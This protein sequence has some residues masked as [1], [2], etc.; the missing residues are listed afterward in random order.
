MKV[1]FL[2]VIDAAD[3]Q[4][5]LMKMASA[6]ELVPNGQRFEVT[7]EDLGK[8]PSS[9]FA[10][11]ASE[12]LRRVFADVKP[13]ETEGRTARV[14]LQSADDFRF[15]R[16]WWEPTCTGARE[17]W[18]CFTKG[19]TFC[20]FYSDVGLVVEW[21]GG[22]RQMKAF[23]ETTPGTRHWSRNLRSIEY[24]FRP[25]ITWTVRTTRNLS[26]RL[27]PSGCIFAHKGPV[28]FVD[29]DNRDDL[30]ALLA[31][32]VSSTFR[33]LVELQLA[34]VDAAARSYEVGVI[35]RTPIPQLDLPGK[36]ALSLLSLKAWSLR[37]TIDMSV[38]SSHAFT[39]PALLQVDGRDFSERKVA[40][41]ERVHA[42]ETEQSRIQN[43]IDTLC[44]EFYGLDK[45]DSGHLQEDRG[46]PTSDESEFEGLGESDFEADLPEPEDMAADI[47]TLVADLVAWAIGVTCGRFDVRL[48]TGARPLP[49]EPDPF[50]VLPVCS[51]GM[52]TGDD[53]LPLAR[54][55]EGY[56]LTFAEDGLLVDD[57]GHP[58]DVTAA[59]RRV[60]DVVFG[61]NS[62]ARWREAAAVLDPVEHD[63][64]MWISRDFFSHH[65][66]RHSKSRRK[67]PLMWQLASSAGSYSVWAYA[68]R[69][70]TDS[71]YQIRGELLGAKIIHE[72]GVLAS[73]VRATGATPT[74]SQRK[75]ISAQ[76]A[77]VAELCSFRD[78]VGRLAPLW[79]PNLDDGVSL[80]MAPLWRLAPLHRAW[81]NELRSSWD[82]LRA[83]KFDWAYGAMHMWPERVVPRCVADRSLAI[84][85]GLADR[86]WVEDFGG[87]WRP[88]RDPEA[89]VAYV[90]A[91]HSS[92]ALTQALQFVRDHWAARSESA[93]LW[94][95]ALEVG[96]HDETAIARA[97]WPDRVARKE[98]ESQ[99]TL[100]GTVSDTTDK[101]KKPARVPAPLLGAQAL[102]TLAA[103]C[104]VLDGYPSWRAKWA[105][106][107]A[108]EFDNRSHLALAVRTAAAVEQAL[109]DPATAAALGLEQ[110]FWLVGEDATRR[111]KTPAE[112]LELAITERHSPAVAEAVKRLVETPSAP[113]AGRGRGRRAATTIEG[114]KR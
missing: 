85:Q 55:P 38:E 31:T 61:D 93:N 19:G 12:Q 43:D 14:G 102:T 8:I 47:A 51:L 13:F 15:L 52:L 109:R 66:K 40:W 58:R 113:A 4:E 78:D 26:L 71:L 2:R 70:T 83:G 46:S 18:V 35:Q 94:W 92:S 24:Y 72:E 63:L 9:P 101:R 96:D 111:L 54:S 82:A 60:F 45:V 62:D 5:A 84:A 107:D 79:R 39:L 29:G 89:E 57:P 7:L 6:P 73:L 25:G 104:S 10:Y 110:W 80:T 20:L 3:K 34:A 28:A 22:G 74:G 114:G 1:V 50:D 56:P 87:T 88:R 36:N 69:L 42:V 23:A 64:R 77:M 106:F 97:L 108:G 91:H 37:R 86:L 33:F 100:L 90:I 112:E 32:M 105:A 103:F 27:V 95:Q 17:R 21:K 67:A 30:L 81:Q 59:V 41:A 49:A 68:H 53:G 11:W 99:G 48:A 98:A 65:L 75:Q 44:L 16:L 76:Q